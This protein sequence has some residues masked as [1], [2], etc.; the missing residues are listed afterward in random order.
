MQTQTD[1]HVV[2][3]AF[4][5]TSVKRAL[6]IVTAILGSGETSTTAAVII[7]SAR[8]AIIAVQRGKHAALDGYATVSGAIVIV[9]ADASGARYTDTGSIANIIFGA[10]IVIVTRSSV[11]FVRITAGASAWVAGTYI[12]ALTECGAMYRITAHTDAIDAGIGLRA[13]VAI[14]AQ[15]A[16]GL[17][18]VAADTSSG[19]TC[20][21]HMTLIE[22]RASYWIVAPTVAVP[23]RVSLRAEI[24]IITCGTILLQRVRAYTGVRIA[25]ALHVTLVENGADNTRTGSTHTLPARVTHRAGVV[26][27]TRGIIVLVG[28]RASAGRGI[29]SADDM[30][31]ILGRADD[32]IGSAANSSLASIGLRAPIAIVAGRT[33][34]LVRVRAEAGSGVT[35]TSSVALVRSTAIHGIRARTDS[36]RANIGAGA[37]VFVITGATIRFGRVRAYSGRGVTSAYVVALV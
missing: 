22:R 17:G 30:T 28:V 13:S 14:R 1:Q 23:A 37:R 12:V 6:I 20:A 27:S 15:R 7:L 11:R 3:G 9:A 34:R 25:G 33:I 35:Y 26:V 5:V 21:S 4:D 16:V 36:S 18:R 31:L 24:A 8:V 10:E 19:V 32:W 2:E 29:T